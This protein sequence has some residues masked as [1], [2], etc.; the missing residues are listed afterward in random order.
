[1][2]RSQFTVEPPPLP[3]APRGVLVVIGWELAAGLWRS[4]LSDPRSGDATCA[5]CR[6]PMPCFCW[7]FADAF[8]AE[9]IASAANVRAV[10]DDA[11]REL[12]QVER[13]RLPR[14]QPGASLPA[15]EGYDGWFTR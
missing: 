6:L 3:H 7:R 5:R 15:E 12:P 2:R 14:R 4:H 13:P 10:A 9:A 11:T 1:M 8:L